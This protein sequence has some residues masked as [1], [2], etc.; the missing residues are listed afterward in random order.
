MLVKG[1]YSIKSLNP[2]VLFSPA[3]ILL[4]EFFYLP[5]YAVHPLARLAQMHQ[6]GNE[7]DHCTYCSTAKKSYASIAVHVAHCVVH[8]AAYPYYKNRH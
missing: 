6:T 2:K 7:S 4:F 5:Q 8:K 3:V 1:E